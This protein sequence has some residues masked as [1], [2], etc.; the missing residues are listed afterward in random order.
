MKNLTKV[1]TI[2][3]VFVSG[4]LCSRVRTSSWPKRN[5]SV[6]RRMGATYFNCWHVAGQVSVLPRV[7]PNTQRSCS[8]ALRVIKATRHTTPPHSLHIH[9]N[10]ASGVASLVLAFFPP[11]FSRLLLPN[12]RHSIEHINW[13]NEAPKR[14]YW[15]PF[16]FFPFIRSAILSALTWFIIGPHSWGR[17]LGPFGF[18]L[19]TF[20]S[21][22]AII[23]LSHCP[24]VPL[25]GRGK[26]KAYECLNNF[27]LRAKSFQF[28]L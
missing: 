1:K 28:S 22:F 5:G 17:V 14:R 24:V 16:K 3:W 20:T 21:V 13:Q 25:Y 7:A 12:F 6:K 9:C 11:G 8:A 18:T 10:N 2:L 15:L 26:W 19:V 4:N 23:P 27:Q